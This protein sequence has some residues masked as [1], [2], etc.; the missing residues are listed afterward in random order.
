[1]FVNSRTYEK[2]PAVIAPFVLCVSRVDV[3]PLGVV[4]VVANGDIVEIVVA[5]FYAADKLCRHENHAL[6]SL[7]PLGAGGEGEVAGVAVGVRIHFRAVVALAADV[8]QGDKGVEMAV[9][10]FVPEIKGGLAPVDVVVCLLGHH[11]FVRGQV[12]IVAAAA[13]FFGSVPVE[14]EAVLIVGAQGSA[15][16][17]GCGAQVG[18]FGE[19]VAVVVVAVARAAL[20]IHGEAEVG[21]AAHYRRVE[22]SVVFKSAADTD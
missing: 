21:V 20:A 18:D 9:V 17:E 12:E 6:E 7:S 22:C 14:G 4:V 19:T 8:L 13:V 1:M 16:T 2:S 11:R 15:G 3:H 5:V 10:L